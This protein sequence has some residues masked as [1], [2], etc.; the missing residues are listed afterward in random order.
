[1]RNGTGLG[2]VDRVASRS[3]PG[4]HDIREGDHLSDLAVE[5]DIK[6][7]V[8]VPIIDNETIAVGFECVLPAG[9]HEEVRH[10]GMGN[11]PC[12]EIRHDGIAIR[13]VHPVDAYDVGTT[14]IE[15]R[16]NTGNQ[17]ICSPAAE[18]DINHSSTL[19]E[20]VWVALRQSGG[21][22]RHGTGLRVYAP[23]GAGERCGDVQRLVRADST[24]LEFLQARNQQGFG[25]LQVS[26][27]LFGI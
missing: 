22:E 10:R 14:G 19:E 8:M 2:E 12:A 1:M 24:A 21:E 27:F 20:R 16:C 9:G 13:A 15:I 25:L 6:Y 5:G 23:D 3:Q 11:G 4:R 17:R 7:A 18:G 26:M